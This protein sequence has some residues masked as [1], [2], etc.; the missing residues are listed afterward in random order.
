MAAGLIAVLAARL[1]PVASLVICLVMG[2]VQ[3]A[4]VMLLVCLGTTIC[5]QLRTSRTFEA[6][7]NVVMLVA[8]WSGVWG[9]Y[10]RWL[11]W[12][13]LIHFAAT[14]LLTLLAR[15]VLQQWWPKDRIDPTASWPS[16]V[17]AAVLCLVWEAMELAGFLFIDPEIYVAPVDTIADIAAGMAGAGAAEYVRRIRLRRRADPPPDPARQPGRRAAGPPECSRDAN[18]PADDCPGASPRRDRTPRGTARSDP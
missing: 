17:I 3:T 16:L 9:L 15:L 6:A 18:R 1:A 2:D 12:D 4:M 10:E 8:A 5:W 7:F 14:G 13:L 11:A